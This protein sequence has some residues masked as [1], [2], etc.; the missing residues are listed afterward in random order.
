[1]TDTLRSSLIT[2]GNKTLPTFQPGVMLRRFDNEPLEFTNTLVRCLARDLGADMISLDLSDLNDLSRDF[3]GQVP[4]PP[5][6]VD[7]SSTNDEVAATSS[8]NPDSGEKS[9][10]EDDTS[11]DST[12]PD[13]PSLT[14]REETNP[15]MFFFMTRSKKNATD[16]AKA[17]TEL[18]MNSLLH[19]L[20]MKAKETADD[21]PEPSNTE[22]TKRPLIIY[23]PE[24]NKIYPLNHE[25]RFFTRWRDFIRAQS[26]LGQSIFLVIS[27]TTSSS[28]CECNSCTDYV[29]IGSIPAKLR[30]DARTSFTVPRKWDD[31][32]STAEPEASVQEKNVRKLKR[33][34]QIQAPMSLHADFLNMSSVWEFPADGKCQKL[35]ESHTLTDEQIHQ[36]SRQLIGRSWDKE[37]LDIKDMFVVLARLSDQLAQHRTEAETT[38]KEEKKEPEDEDWDAKIEAI[39][40]DCNKY[41]EG[42][43]DG[44]VNPSTSARSMSLDNTNV[45]QRNSLE[46]TTPSSSIRRQRRL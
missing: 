37:A 46:D 22:P 16:D 19:G 32:S 39:R 5:K 38:E 24:S 15:T 10:T 3:L 30:I 31:G 4:K 12:A 8:D 36:V 41:E 26:K 7:V 34:L 11:A 17:R 21:E 6:G 9:T 13:Y 1:V 45:S 42:L 18:A 29:G 40:G 43:L 44:V 23:V 14:S 27:A 35:I 33:T 25:R 20:R 2:E 28:S